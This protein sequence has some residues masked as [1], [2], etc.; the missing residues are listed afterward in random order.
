M[1]RHKEKMQLGRAD[2]KPFTIPAWYVT[3]TA[4]ILGKRG[5]GKS[6][7]GNVIAEELLDCR[8][9]I[10]VIDP[11]SS[12]WGL[13]SSADGKH[14]GYPI[15]IFGEDHADLPLDDIAGPKIAELVVE[16]PGL[17]VILSLDHLSKTS[18]RK[19]VMGFSET[20]YHL[21][22]GRGKQ[23]PLHIFIDEADLFIPQK[24]IHGMER[25][26]G[27]INDLVRR[28]R[29]YGIG[30]TLLTQR[31]AVINK[32]VLSQAEI[33]IAGQVT[34]K[35]DRDAIR[36]WIRYNADEVRLKEFLTSLALLQRGTLWV[37]S[38]GRLKVLVQLQVRKR[39]T[40]D[41]SATPEFK[42]TK[43]KSAEPKRMSRVELKQVRSS[44]ESLVK[45]SEENDPKALKR[46]VAR[47]RKELGQTQKQPKGKAP[48]KAAPAGPPLDGAR[49]ARKVE[50]IH[51]DYLFNRIGAKVGDHIAALKLRICGTI[52]SASLDSIESGVVREIERTAKALEREL[53]KPIKVPDLLKQAGVIPSKK[54]EPQGRPVIPVASRSP[55][56]PKKP[57][58]TQGDVF[59]V[60]VGKG[61]RAVLTVLAQ[62]G[63]PCSKRLVA[64]HS[65]YSIKSGSFSN[66]LSSLRRA[67]LIVGSA[68]EP[69][70][71]TGEG[72]AVVGD[73]EPL[74]SGEELIEHWSVLLGRCERTVLR[75]VAEAHPEPLTKEDIAGRAGYIVSSGSFSNAI[76]KLRGLE[77][78][79]GKGREPIRLSSEVFD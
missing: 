76:S 58:A 62:H 55:A 23:T 39:R 37:W 35:H 48:V 61:E 4:A 50:A 79:Q 51:N 29:K 5:S 70:E 16:N 56:R 73:Y 78:I 22:H 57:A 71:I 34:G 20:L 74:P 25:L 64:L 33:L 21:K 17:S 36:D 43:Q 65:G 63:R 2:G 59:D 9:Q 10:V 30:V 68:S 72:L 41:S 28:G 1:P 7:L 6:Y 60:N 24:V 53:G 32:D 38:P 47:L 15:L 49:I 14:E 27:T 77:L 75:T 45:R 26:V 11:T 3:E 12:W 42:G 18:Q 69:I 19:F 67:G 13:R 52:R 54:G 66:S 8:Q 46:E 44:L 40:F 31:P